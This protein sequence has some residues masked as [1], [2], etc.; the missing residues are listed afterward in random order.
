MSFHAEYNAY[1][2][3]FAEKQ[4]R[5]TVYLNYLGSSDGYRES[6]Q[7]ENGYSL[8]DRGVLFGLSVYF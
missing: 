7:E 8:D 1:I 6:L 2:Y 5:K 4:Y 3:Y